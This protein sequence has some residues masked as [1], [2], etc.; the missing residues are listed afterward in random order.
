MRKITQVMLVFFL[1]ISALATYVAA[2][3]AP[4]LPLVIKGNVTINNAP[5][6]A[7]TR[8]FAV[9]NGAEA[10]STEVTTPGTYAFI[11]EGTL[12]DNGKDIAIYVNNII[13][14]KS[15]TWASGKVETINLAVEQ[16][17]ATTTTAK[18]T[19][20]TERRSSGGGSGGSREHSSATTTTASPSTTTTTTIESGG[21]SE[22]ITPTGAGNQDS[23]KTNQTQKISSPITTNSPPI[24][25]IQPRRG[26]STSQVIILILVVL[27][28]AVLFA[29][30]AYLRQDSK[31]KRNI[32]A[33]KK[34]VSRRKSR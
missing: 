18:A 5:A 3:S 10:G 32:N 11:V 14:D 28:L 12:A 25:L 4:V 23:Q 24:L 21:S 2:E 29:I 15:T 33:K 17:Q 9:M 19:T 27:I 16:A 7:G 34:R 8:V 13:T 6:P 1:I 20:T 22:I 31:P 26:I 30:A